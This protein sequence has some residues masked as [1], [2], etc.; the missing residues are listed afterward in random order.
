MLRNLS[1]YQDLYVCNFYVT[2]I[3]EMLRK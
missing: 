1:R 3:L 2:H